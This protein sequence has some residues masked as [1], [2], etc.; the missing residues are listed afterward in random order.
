MAQ[1]ITAQYQ[2]SDRF[3]GERRFEVLNDRYLKVRN[4]KLKQQ[5]K[6]T[7]ELAILDP[8]YSTI[9]DRAIHWLG[10]IGVTALAFVAFLAYLF[11]HFSTSLLLSALPF[12][13]ISGLLIAAFYILYLFQSDHR[14]V[15]HTQHARYPMVDIFHHG[16][17]KKESE[18]FANS[19]SKLIEDA[20]ERLGYNDEELQAGEVRTLRRLSKEQ[21]IDTNIYEQAK[22]RILHG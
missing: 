22:Q 1:E 6:Y 14:F 18:A 21:V 7:F 20:K 8:K 5:Q 17:F 19:L 9:D 16:H 15:F 10:A 4:K 2:Q 3:K 13:I 12:F 11:T